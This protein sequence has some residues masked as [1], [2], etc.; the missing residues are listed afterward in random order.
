MMKIQKIAQRKKVPVP[1]RRVT[2]VK[3]AIPLLKQNARSALSSFARN[4]R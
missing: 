2:A 4:L 3:A 1:I